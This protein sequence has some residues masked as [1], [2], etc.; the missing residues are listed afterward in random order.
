MILS[1]A[2]TTLSNILNKDGNIKRPVAKPKFSDAEVITLSLLAEILM[3]DCENYLF[4]K[5]NE[6]YKN[7]F[8]N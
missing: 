3:I 6:N 2:K 4:R 7:F 5:L 1:F 8:L